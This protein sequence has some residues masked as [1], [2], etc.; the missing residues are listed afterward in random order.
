MDNT[1]QR[2][3]N[4]LHATYWMGTLCALGFVAVL[5]QHK[6][7]TNTEI[8]VVTG[9]SSLTTIVLSPVVSGVCAKVKRFSL[10][11]QLIGFFAVESLL[12]SAIVF[13]PLPKAL[14]MGLYIA[15][16]ALNISTV[17]LVS[18][19][20]MNYIADGKPVNF[21]LSR[22]IGS[23]SYALCAIVA[24]Q[25]V[26]WF[27]PAALGFLFL[28]A[29]I[30]CVVVLWRMPATYSKTEAKA[31]CAASVSLF[32]LAGRYRLFFGLL[33]GFGLAFAAS[34]CVG[35]YLINIVTSLGGDAS[36]L[37]VA[38]FFMAASELPVMAVAPRLMRRFGA[39]SLLAAA[40]LFYIARNGLVCVAPRLP[41][42]F[43]GLAFQGL[44]YGLFTPIM[45]YYV[46]ENLAK[47]HQIMGQTMIG[48]MTS[49][50][51]SAIGNTAGGMLQDAYGM[52]TMLRFV[53][54]LTLAGALMVVS[55]RQAG[56]KQNVPQLAKESN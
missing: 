21:G 36:M 15:M 52:E 32:G 34:A 33:L 8:G 39:K 28:G 13:L 50:F 55:L 42:L 40:A 49:G 24:G 20:A 56:K 12:F 23:I 53:L 44:S 43:A 27:S 18:T 37:G 51:G 31:D 14:L 45:T 47:E 2:K 25:L 22:G 46:A 7:L 10:Q 6:G 38:T 41:V 54:A 4:A 11:Q 30:L 1:M 9:G 48:V 5:L 19:I 26:G 16:Y 3:Y 35:T 29:N 17:P